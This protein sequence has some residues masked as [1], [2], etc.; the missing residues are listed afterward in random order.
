MLVINL[1]D[2][3]CG[4][5]PP[6][7]ER[8]KSIN[9]HFLIVTISLIILYFTSVL[10][11]VA[12]P[13]QKL[14]NWIGA[15]SSMRFSENW[16]LF[17]QGELRTWEMASNLNELLWRVGGVYQINGKLSAA[18]GYVRVDTW[19]Y[20]NEPYRKFYENRSYQDF[21]IKSNWVKNIAIQN[22]FRLEQRW[23]TFRNDGVEYSNRI[24]YMLSFNIPIS[25]NA[26]KNT[27]NYVAVF[28]EI[29]LDFDRFDYWFDREAGKSGLNQ[30]RLYAGVGHRFSSNSALQL[31]LLWQHRPNSDFWR[32][33]LGYS[34]NF[35]FRKI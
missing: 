3:L 11:L 31:G 16:Q 26:E 23:I 7:V 2:L 8:S 15:T 20:D 17:L 33:M 32:L 10:N 14:G 9:K 27:S 29:F 6:Y 22:R 34:R 4:N 35:D 21:V 28:N 13:E 12:Q 30:N 24:R 18:I 19:P 1:P 5:K 25:Q